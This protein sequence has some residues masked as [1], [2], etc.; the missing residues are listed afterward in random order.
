M[1]VLPAGWARERDPPVR[2]LPELGSP[3]PGALAGKVGGA[4]S[5]VELESV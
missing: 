1:V 4:V 3:A 2:G 5:R